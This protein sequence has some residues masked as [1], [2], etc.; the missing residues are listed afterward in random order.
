MNAFLII[1]GSLVT[2]TSLLLIEKYQL[3]HLNI[4]RILGKSKN[5]IGVF[6]ITIGI[7]PFFLI[8]QDPTSEIL[9][10]SKLISI[11]H[12]VL[13][14]LI[15]TKHK[16]LLSFIEYQFERDNGYILLFLNLFIGLYLLNTVLHLAKI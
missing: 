4:S 7:I 12:F 1:W 2:G 13:G 6:I 8:V 5:L 15:L 3:V 14:V 10:M 9:I 11:F 16:V